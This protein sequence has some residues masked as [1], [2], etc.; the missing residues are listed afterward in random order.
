[1]SSRGRLFVVAGPSGAGKTTVIREARKLVDVDLSVSVTTRQP[2]PGEVDGVDYI[3][4][5]EDEFDR[6]AEASEFLEWEEVYG[7]RYGTPRRRVEEAL[8]RGRDVLL[9][10]DVKGARA[11][12]ASMPGALLVFVMPPSEGALRE[13]LEG[14]ADGKTE[15]ESRLAVAPVELEAG[16]R[17]FDLVIVNDVLESAADKLAKVL[18]GE[19]F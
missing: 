12:K 3:F 16:T 7:S 15:I 4:V 5:T 6:L 10:I 13:R 2:R 18:R 9:E 1:M 8:E 11:V 14:R 17:E 19:A